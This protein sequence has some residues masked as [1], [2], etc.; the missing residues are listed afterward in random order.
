VEDTGEGIDSEKLEE[1]N[2][3]SGDEDHTSSG[4]GLTICKELALQMGGSMEISSEQGLG[5]TIWVLL[6]CH[7]DVIKRKKT[8]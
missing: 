5:T 3:N 2:R 1:L 8:V 6:P 4:L 7:A